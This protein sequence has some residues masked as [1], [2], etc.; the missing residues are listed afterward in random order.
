MRGCTPTLVN[1]A[2]R[3]NS[4][5]AKFDGGIRNPPPLNMIWTWRKTDMGNWLVGIYV[6]N[7]YWV[8]TF[9]RYLYQKVRNPA[10][11]CFDIYDEQ[12]EE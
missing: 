12:G 6:G 4:G 3:I 1:T 10:I 8:T 2:E 9:Y 7:E 11:R 5:A